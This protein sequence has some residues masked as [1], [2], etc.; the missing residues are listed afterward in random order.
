VPLRKKRPV[1]IPNGLVGYSQPKSDEVYYEDGKEGDGVIHGA[2]GDD[3]QSPDTRAAKKQGFMG[4]DDDELSSD[5]DIEGE[6]YP[7]KK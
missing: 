6:S 5:D 4:D 7:L 2:F 3:G 1:S